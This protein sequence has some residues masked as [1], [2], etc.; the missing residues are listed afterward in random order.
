M[1]LG[2]KAP[3]YDVYGLFRAS[4][5]HYLFYAPLLVG[6]ENHCPLDNVCPRGAFILVGNCTPTKTNLWL[7]TY[8]FRTKINC[9]RSISVGTHAYSISLISSSGCVR[10][11][12][13][14]HFTSGRTGTFDAVW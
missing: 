11:G 14:N 13:I 5:F 8:I 3:N 9:F 10:S 2:S 4:H 7:A 12:T 6:I 1:M